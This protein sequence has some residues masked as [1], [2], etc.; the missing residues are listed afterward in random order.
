MVA[1]IIAPYPV[2]FWKSYA[3]KTSHSSLDLG[4]LKVSAGFLI[5]FST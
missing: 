3:L 5:I 4:V 2:V 1:V